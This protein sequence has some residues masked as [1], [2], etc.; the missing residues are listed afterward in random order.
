MVL[1][2]SSRDQ[3][4]IDETESFKIG[5]VVVRLQSTSAEVREEFSS[6]YDGYQVADAIA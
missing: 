3:L 1:S 2:N 4:R 6:L 5:E